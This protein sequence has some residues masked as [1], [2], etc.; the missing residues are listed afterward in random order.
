MASIIP[1]SLGLAAISTMT[2]QF[3]QRADC[4]QFLLILKKLFRRYF[5]LLLD[6]RICKSPRFGRALFLTYGD[7]ARHD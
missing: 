6:L 2:N 5:D 3:V 4:L 7:L 1:N